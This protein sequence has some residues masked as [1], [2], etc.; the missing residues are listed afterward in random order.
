MVLSCYR[1][2]GFE[3]L[4]GLMGKPELVTDP[5][6]DTMEKRVKNN[7][8]L[9]K[10]IEAWL[11]KFEKVGDA[12]A[13]LQS[14]RIMAAPVLSVTQIIEEDPQI[15]VREMLKE[16]EHRTLGL[17]K[18]LNTP[19][20]FRNSEASVDGPPPAFAGEHTDAI[21]Q[22]ILKLSGEEIKKLRTKGIVS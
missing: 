20:R 12:V 14:Y 8:E 19:L 16:I 18:F 17:I 15:K 21:L 1:P 4:A 9:T 13:F 10:L 5:R 3:R 22:G 6:F 2:I 11:K 7:R